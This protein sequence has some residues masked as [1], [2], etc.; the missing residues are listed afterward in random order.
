MKAIVGIVILS[1]SFCSCQS[2]I[3]QDNVTLKDITS[4]LRFAMDNEVFSKVKSNYEIFSYFDYSL[5]DSTLYSD[6]LGVDTVL[7]KENV[8]YMA[9]QYRQLAKKEIKS[10]ISP[11]YNNLVDDYSGNKNIIHFELSA[12]MFSKD[13]KTFVLH[14]LSIFNVNGKPK[15][16]DLYFVFSKK[17]ENWKLNGLIKRK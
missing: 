4:A 1:L 7:D 8:Y 3:K 17:S 2:Q 13:K 16:D 6:L 14:V 9:E 5:N 15:W 11:V 12:P 10:F